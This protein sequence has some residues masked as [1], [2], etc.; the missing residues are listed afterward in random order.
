VGYHV[1]ARHEIWYF[2]VLVLKPRLE[3]GPV[4]AD[5]TINVVYSYKSLRNYLKPVYSLTPNV[6]E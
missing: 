2:G 4:T 5:M 1:Y 6:F 3:S